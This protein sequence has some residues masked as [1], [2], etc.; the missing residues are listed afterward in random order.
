MSCLN[1]DWRSSLGVYKFHSYLN[2]SWNYGFHPTWITKVVPMVVK[3]GSYGCEKV[4][5]RLEKG[6]T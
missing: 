5:P 1:G 4:V 2:W 3:G 6:S